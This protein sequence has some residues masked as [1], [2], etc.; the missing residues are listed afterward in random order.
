MGVPVMKKSGICV[1]LVNYL[2]AE[3]LLGG[4]LPIK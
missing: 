1:Y 2:V 3:L 4:S